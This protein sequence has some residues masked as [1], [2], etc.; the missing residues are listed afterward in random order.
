MRRVMGRWGGQE[1]AG[2]DGEEGNDGSGVEADTKIEYTW[3]RQ[4][5]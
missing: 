5:V 1:L 4:D 2:M 3:A